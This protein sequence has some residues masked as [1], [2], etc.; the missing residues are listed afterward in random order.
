ME[1]LWEGKTVESAIATALKELNCTEPDVEIEVV[2]E[3]VK[4]IFGIVKTAKVRVVRRV[5]ES[6]VEER[7][8][9]SP[10][11][12]RP[13]SRDVIPEDQERGVQAVETL[14]KLMGIEST[15]VQGRIENGS[16]I[17]DLASDAEGLLIGR[18]GRTREA[19]QYVVDRIANQNQKEK[20]KYIIDIGGYLNRHK[21]TL[22][23]LAQRTAEK[24]R[25]QH[26]SE[27]LPSMNAFD[28]R[29]VHLFLK[30]HPDVETR[31]EGEGEARHILILERRSQARD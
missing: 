15:R 28:R 16:V 8:V 26:H 4:G 1:T 7:V 31:S 18:H 22:E 14:L 9:A 25:T 21:E 3:P 12:V 11:R 19:L 27:P 10:T 13:V 2:Q 29:I 23:N 30:D 6:R 20:I 17:L 24:V 5:Q